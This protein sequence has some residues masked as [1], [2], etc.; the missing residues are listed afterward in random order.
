MSAPADLV[1]AASDPVFAGHFPGHPIVPGAL[2]LDQAL[3]VARAR[4]LP[5]VRQI[6]RVKFHQTLG[7][8]TPCSVAVHR[9]SPAVFEL[10]CRSDG[11]LVL[12]AVIVSDAPV[13]A[14]H[15]TQANAIETPS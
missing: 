6:Q 1:F 15:S 5:P 13:V 3:A 8:D 4:G 10:E 12:T 2:L 11:S 9:R 7:P 14:G